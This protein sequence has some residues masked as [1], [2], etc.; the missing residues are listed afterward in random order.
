MKKLIALFLVLVVCFSLCACNG[1]E[2]KN[3]VS[4]DSDVLLDVENAEV[5]VTEKYVCHSSHYFFYLVV[6]EYDGYRFTVDIEDEEFLLV[7]VGDTIVTDIEIYNDSFHGL[8][9]KFTVGTKEQTSLE[10]IT[11]PTK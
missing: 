4:V 3:G 1:A 6:M 7:E 10:C 5:V 8:K 9:A 11:L 2:E